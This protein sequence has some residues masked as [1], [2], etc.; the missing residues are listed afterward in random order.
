MG[1]RWIQ[2]AEAVDDPVVVERSYIGS[3]SSY[4]GATAWAE[5]FLRALR[6]RPLILKLLLRPIFGKYAYREFIG[7]MDALMRNGE[8]PY[9]DYGLESMD[10]HKDR[11]PWRWWD[12]REP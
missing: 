10:Y 1:Q 12:E 7:L 11:V 6:N 2:G 9:Y 5:D 8:S 4:I 3:L